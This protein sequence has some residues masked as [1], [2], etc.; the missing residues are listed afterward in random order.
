MRDAERGATLTEVLVVVTLTA[1]LSIP[2]YQMMASAFRLERSQTSSS[3]AER[4][5]A[6]VV[7]RFQTDL[8]SG[9]PAADLSSTAGALELAIVVDASGV[10]RLVTWSF[11]RGTLRRTVTTVDAGT[12]VSDVV[13]AEG[14]DPD[15]SGFT[16]FDGAG[17]VIAAA[18]RNRITECAVRATLS[19]TVE[20]RD[21]VAGREITVAHRTFEPEET[22]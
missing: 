15:A 13:L 20:T 4:Q 14:I 19:V 9:R 21:S 17:R 6:L 1:L 10:E 3:D 16:Y 18:D 11:D 5:L 8:R 2:L 12:V 7:E 22:C